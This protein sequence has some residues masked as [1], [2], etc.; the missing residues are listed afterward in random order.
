MNINKYAAKNSVNTIEIASVLREKLQESLSVTK[1]LYVNLFYSSMQKYTIFLFT[2]Q[3]SK[4]LT[5]F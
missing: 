4:I 1:K 3:K 5:F 2:K